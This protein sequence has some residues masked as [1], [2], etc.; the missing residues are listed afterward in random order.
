MLSFT[1]V[2]FTTVKQARFHLTSD[3]AAFTGES[4]CV[5]SQPS[6]F[7]YCR[8]ISH[9]LYSCM[10]KYSDI[11]SEPE[12]NSVLSQMRKL[13]NNGAFF[14]FPFFLLS[15]R[16]SVSLNEIEFNVGFPPKQMYDF[17]HS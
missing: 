6:S 12:F 9:I 11:S 14:F 2:I 16:I 10:S 1:Q 7:Y 15:S 4:F 3:A 13:R 5:V 8:C 17:P